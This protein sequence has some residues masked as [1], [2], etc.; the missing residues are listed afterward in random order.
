MCITFTSSQSIKIISGAMVSQE[1]SV[2]WLLPLTFNIVPEDI[3]N[4]K[5][6]ERKTKGIWI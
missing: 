5:R 4:A 1:P 6:Q 3:N 2:Y